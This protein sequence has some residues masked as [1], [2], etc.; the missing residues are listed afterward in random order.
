[1]PYSGGWDEQPAAWIDMVDA[2]DDVYAIYSKREADRERLKQRAR[3]KAG[4]R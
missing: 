1:M 4:I 2:F 3:G